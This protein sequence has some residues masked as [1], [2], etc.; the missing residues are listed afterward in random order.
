M[1]RKKKELPPLPEGWREETI[2]HVKK[3]FLPEIQ[4]EALRILNRKETVT[5]LAYMKDAD[6]GRFSVNRIIK[7]L[8]IC[9]YHASVKPSG[10]SFYRNPKVAA[11]LI[12]S[13]QTVMKELPF[14]FDEEDGVSTERTVF[15]E[16]IEF[17]QLYSSCRR[18]RPP[19]TQ[20][21]LCLLHMETQF[22]K[23]FGRAVHESIA[24]WM[25]ATFPRDYREHF[26]R[27]RPPVLTIIREL[28]RARILM[29]SPAKDIDSNP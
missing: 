5:A 18:G 17:I 21:Y 27:D 13:L 4:E 9:A 22:N 10:G 3:N 12:T 11:R 20:K 23:W 1:A 6:P 2:E 28:K 16:A 14:L 7:V 25:K 24:A 19:R 26:E 8:R 15:E 29:R